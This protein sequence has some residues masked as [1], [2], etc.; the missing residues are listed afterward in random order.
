MM[1]PNRHLPPAPPTITG[2]VLNPEDPIRRP[3][4]NPD[5]VPTAD[6]AAPPGAVRPAH[7]FLPSRPPGAY[8]PTDPQL[9]WMNN[10]PFF[11]HECVG[12]GGFGKVYKAEMMLPPGMEVARDPTTG[13]FI[14]D[15]HGRV[16]V[17][18][19]MTERLT[20]P[21]DPLPI[22]QDNSSAPPVEF[23]ENTDAAL[24][25]EVAQALELSEVVPRGMNFFSVEDI[26]ENADG[27]QG[28]GSGT[29]SVK[30]LRAAY[31][32]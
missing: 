27:N 16:A 13:A 11:L 15:E 9:F 21:D 5:Y 23:I 6:A 7:P 24:D 19:V 14:L 8:D 28:L 10:R 3:P 25:E 22:E 30:D 18:A 32:A 31:G 4:L 12:K 1:G 26:T 2:G 29:L 17:E 20:T